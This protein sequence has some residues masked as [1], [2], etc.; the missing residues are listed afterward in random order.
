MTLRGKE[1][2]KR[3]KPLGIKHHP[4]HAAGTRDKLL[5][6]ALHLFVEQG[7]NG[8]STKQICA[9]AGAN[10]AAVTY[11]FETKE[12]L[13]N[14]LLNDKIDERASTFS[15]ILK[16]VHSLQDLKIRVSMYCE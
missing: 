16:E 5:R 9:A 8:T 7:Y 1:G 15:L 3:K 6:A 2:S 14:E 10:I 13:L 4:E 11:H 12:N